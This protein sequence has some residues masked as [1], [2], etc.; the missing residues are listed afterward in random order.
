MA[1]AAAAGAE[2]EASEEAESPGYRAAADPA[3]I[4]GA[5]GGPPAGAIS[6]TNPPVKV[7]FS[8]LG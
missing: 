1:A 5:A 8:A 2:E 3:R 7:V 6:V 4:P